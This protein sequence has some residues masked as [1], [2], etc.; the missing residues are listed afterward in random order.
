M[1][2]KM[3]GGICI[4]SA[5]TYLGFERAHLLYKRVKYIMNIKT[6]LT[7]LESEIGF[8]ANR[9]DSA[10]MTISKLSDTQGLFSQTA[11]KLQSVGIKEAWEMSV[12]A[13]REKM[14]LTGEDTEILLSFGAELGMTDRENQIKNIRYITSLLE[15]QYKE[16]KEEYERMART[17]RSIGI[18]SG[19]FLIVLLI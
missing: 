6:S 10:F 19:L 16:A 14:R 9:L 7:M 8:C 18:L 4:L 5:T 2:A 17:Y 11:K 13:H 1:I 3:M 12:R 15:K